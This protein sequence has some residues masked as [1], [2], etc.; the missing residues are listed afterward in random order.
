MLSVAFLACMVICLSGSSGIT[1]TTG[2]NGTLTTETIWQ[3]EHTYTPATATHSHRFVW[4]DTPEEAL[5]LANQ[6]ATVT[7]T[8]LDLTA[9]TSAD[10]KA[11]Y[12]QLLINVD[13][14]TKDYWL[15]VR[16]NGTSPSYYPYLRVNAD[17]AHAGDLQ[18]DMVIVGC[19]TGEVIEYYAYVEAGGQAD[20]LIYV[21]GYWE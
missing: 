7:W 11:V 13:T 10:A 8:D 5:S 9:Y 18:T 17:N 3:E 15:G 2:S 1:H 19:D 16:K 4:K 21:M 12:L 14:A 6:A 20:F